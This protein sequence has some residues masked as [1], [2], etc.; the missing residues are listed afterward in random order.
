MKKIFFAISFNLFCFY[1]FSQQNKR[2]KN[3][4]INTNVLNLFAKGPSIAV[5]IPLGRKISIMASA[6]SGQHNYGNLGGLHKYKSLELEIRNHRDNTYFGGY[7]KQVTKT[8]NSEKASF[9]F[10]PISYDRDFKGNAF[11]FGGTTGIEAYVGKRLHLDFNGQIGFGSYYKMTEKYPYNLPA[12]NFVDFRMAF[13][14][15]FRL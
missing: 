11:A 9:I 4:T 1:C 10:I 5:D 13:W 12:S 3:V 7:I 14:V 6:A 2:E 8:V 15:G